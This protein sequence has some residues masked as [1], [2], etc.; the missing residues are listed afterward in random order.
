[1]AGGGKE[2]KINY[3]AS[4]QGTR[5]S[6]IFKFFIVRADNPLRRAPQVEI[7]EAESSDDALSYLCI[8]LHKVPALSLSYAIPH[9]RG[10]SCVPEQE[11]Y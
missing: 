10:A 5:F 7:F 3:F 4:L 9:G 8:I 6:L 11:Q 1:M 2:S